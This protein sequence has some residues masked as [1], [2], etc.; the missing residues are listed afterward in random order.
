MPLAPVPPEVGDY[1]AEP[2]LAV[3]ASLRPDGAP[4][5]AATW[6]G[7]DGKRILLNMDETR[8]RLAFMRADPRVSLT[9]PDRSFG[10][11]QANHRMLSVNGRVVEIRDDTDLADI[12]ALSLRYTGAPFANRG[13]RRVT[14]LVEIESWYGWQGA[15]PWPRSPEARPV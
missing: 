11:P 9:I 14:A 3:V 13:R 2:H 4:H 5:T 10:F 8:L 7:W 12:D 6:Y 1:L 15:G